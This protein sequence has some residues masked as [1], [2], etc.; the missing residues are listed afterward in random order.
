MVAGCGWMRGSRGLFQGKTFLL[1]HWA[2]AVLGGSENNILQMAQYIRKQGGFVE[3]FTYALNDPVK[4]IIEDEGFSV[5]LD[6][7]DLLD[8]SQSTGVEYDLN[9]IDYIVVC[10]NVIPISII[11]QLNRKNVKTKFIFFHMSSFIGIAMES[12]L[13]Y[14]LESKIAS[15]ILTISEEVTSQQLERLL[16]VGIK[17]L[18]YYRNPVP[19][20]FIEGGEITVYPKK[21]AR[22]AVI[23]N[24]PPEEIIA[25]GSNARLAIEGVKVDFIGRWSDNAQ[26][27][28][29]ELLNGYDAII[30]IGKTVQYCLVVGVPVYIYDRFGGQG[31]LKNYN[32]AK[33]TNFS[34]RDAGKRT[35]DEIVGELID[36]YGDA[37]HYQKVNIELFRK[38]FLLSR[39]INS[40][41]SGPKRHL[42]G[43][44][45]VRYLNYLISMQL[46]F[47][48]KNIIMVEIGNLQLVNSGISSELES[49]KNELAQKNNELDSFLSMRRSIRLLAGNIKRRLLDARI[50]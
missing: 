45:S 27:V 35:T 20:E 11:K 26:L 47:K 37:V 29:R 32:D 5:R 31:Y 50:R 16:G 44:F 23:S 1:T 48:E 10:Q 46:L 15:K 30:S 2:L 39:V 12:P 8:Q 41:F 9:D 24:H 25:L 17:N 14:E 33:A 34:G 6:D 4:R 43:D 28:T 19:D 36:G 49:V 42:R 21:P 7:I 38:E 40:V 13:L 3:F 18:S 22:V